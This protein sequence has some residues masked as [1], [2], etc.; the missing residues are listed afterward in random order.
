[1]HSEKGQHNT[2]CL[3]IIKHKEVTTQLRSRSWL[4]GRKTHPCFLQA[5]PESQLKDACRGEHALHSLTSNAPPQSMT[6]TSSSS[7]V[8]LWLEAWNEGPAAALTCSS[9][10]SSTSVTMRTGAATGRPAGSLN[11]DF[12][13]PGFPFG[14]DEGAAFPGDDFRCCFFDAVCSLYSAE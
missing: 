12:F 4:E 9:S 11:G 13:G 7:M 6:T 5:H 8:S 2:S 14:E 10:S 3:F 1:M